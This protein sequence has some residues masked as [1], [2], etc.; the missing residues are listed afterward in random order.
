MGACYYFDDGF[1]CRNQE[2][3]SAHALVAVACM[4]GDTKHKYRIRKQKG[5]YKDENVF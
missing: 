5:I 2:T 1:L 4:R 3:E